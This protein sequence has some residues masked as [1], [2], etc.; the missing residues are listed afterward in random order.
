MFRHAFFYRLTSPAATPPSTSREDNDCCLSVAVA[1]PGQRLP[2]SGSARPSSPPEVLDLSSTPE[3]ASNSKEKV[4]GVQLE[5]TNVSGPH[6]VDEN[7]N[8]TVFTSADTTAAGSPCD[9]TVHPESC[10]A[11]DHAE[12]PEECSLKGAK[13]DRIHVGRGVG[14]G[15]ARAVDLSNVSREARGSS[16]TGGVFSAQP[17][18]PGAESIV[19]RA[20]EKEP[21]SS[22]G[23]VVEGYGGG[24]V[25]GG[26]RGI[27]SC[28]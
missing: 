13:G 2:S 25:G 7:S 18:L 9:D 11:R 8:T 6:H 10:Q 5:T 1:A 3:N 16:V 17:L 22:L 21:K 15:G 20:Y 26:G 27:G 19:R 23:G 14:V 12:T 24:T 4:E 28:S